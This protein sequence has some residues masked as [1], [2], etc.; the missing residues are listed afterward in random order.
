MFT[1]VQCARFFNG[2]MYFTPAELSILRL[3]LTL[4][5]K[6]VR[7]DFFEE[8]MRVRRRERALWA[9]TPVA[10]LFADPGEWGT[11]R[12]TVVGGLIEVSL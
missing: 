9:D 6:A 1:A 5:H 3:A 10:R 8:C 4:T 2:E 7:K 12:F 11:T